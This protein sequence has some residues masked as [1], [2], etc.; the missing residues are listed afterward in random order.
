MDEETFFDYIGSFNPIDTISYLSSY[1]LVPLNSQK[2]PMIEFAIGS[3]ISI[4]KM[5]KK[6]PKRQV[7]K[8]LLSE[9]GRFF[10]FFSPLD[11]KNPLADIFASHYHF[12][13]GDASYIQTVEA[14][15]K[16]FLPY[17][18]IIKRKFGFT[19][20]QALSFSDAILGKITLQMMAFEPEK[21]DFNHTLSKSQYYDPS[22]YVEPPRDLTVTWTKAI[23]FSVSDLDRIINKNRKAFN[24]F[25]DALT[26]DFEES[27]KSKRFLPQDRFW[28]NPIWKKPIIKI[29]SNY[30]IPFPPYILRCLPRLFHNEL[31]RDAKFRGK[32]IAIKGE[33]AESRLVKILNGIFP[34]RAIHKRV[35]YG[36]SYGFPDVDAVVEHKDFLLFFECTSHLISKL[37]KI[38]N[39]KSVLYDLDKTVKKCYLQ[40]KRAKQAYER[41]D[42]HI[43]IRGRP[44]RLITI[45]VTDTPYPNL[46]LDLAHGN[47]LKSFID[48]DDYPYIV[49]VNDL[50]EITS[51][52]NANLLVKFIT[53]RIN[54][55]HHPRIFCF[56]E[57]DYF[58]LFLKP[59]YEEMKAEVLS[60]VE[61]FFYVGHGPL[62]ALSSGQNWV[63]SLKR[64]I[65][66]DQFMLLKVGA[67]TL[68]DKINFALGV[69]SE[70]YGD[71]KEA[72]NHA[73]LDFPHYRQI[74]K[75][76]K[77]LGKKCKA[78]CWEGMEQYLRIFRKSREVRAFVRK[79]ETRRINDE[80]NLL[81][82]FDSNL[83]DEILKKMHNH[84]RIGRTPKY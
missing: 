36:K 12:I 52:T 84:K 53:E 51:I 5:G 45:I 48:Q 32:Y 9:R 68:R 28:D 1:Q 76:Y 27:V 79:L 39:M 64:L 34:K 3:F 75:S 81:I 7:L 41:G 58:R 21:V 54:L 23:K 49:S 77:R 46:S 72:L 80:V 14:I 42:L 78:I 6:K 40:A 71:P 74:V 69:L 30:L 15:S 83:W 70:I 16:H 73:I 56:D 18:T 35:R 19:V 33:I 13:R 31:I 4:S 44:T 20:S 24:S 65:E 59:E 50:E 26:F 10:F 37:A 22:F 47:Y 55:S 63:A 61:N 82:T 62:A 38:G 25:L 8:K 57:K 17:N 11:R 43:P 29:S 60:K 67:P 2:I 66:L